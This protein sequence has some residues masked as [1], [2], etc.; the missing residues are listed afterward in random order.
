MERLFIASPV[1]VILGII[2]GIRWN[3]W[4]IITD[5]HSLKNFLRHELTEVKAFFRD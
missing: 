2:I 3:K 4:Q 5:D 1:I